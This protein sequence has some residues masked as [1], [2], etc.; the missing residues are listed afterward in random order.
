MPARTLGRRDYRIGMVSHVRIKWDNE[1]D[2]LLLGNVDIKY[3]I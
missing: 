3:S 2:L 1:R